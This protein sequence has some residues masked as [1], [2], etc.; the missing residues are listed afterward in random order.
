VLAAAV[1]THLG[2]G[3]FLGMWTFGLIMLVGNMA[4]LPTEGV[5]RVVEALIRRRPGASVAAG[6]SHLAP[7]EPVPWAGEPVDDHG[8]E[9]A[10]LGGHLR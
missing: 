4:F 10:V 7:E 3:A 6:R 9:A 8:E 5:R 1:G 2:I